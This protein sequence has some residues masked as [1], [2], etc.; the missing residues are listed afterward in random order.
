MLNALDEDVLELLAE[1]FIKRIL[2]TESEFIWKKQG[3]DVHVLRYPYD[4]GPDKLDD[5]APM[6][7]RGVGC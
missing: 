3:D 1:A 5:H 6:R 4:P 7:K 2:N